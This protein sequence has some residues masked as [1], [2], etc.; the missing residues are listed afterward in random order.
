MTESEDPQSAPAFLE[1]ADIETASDDYASRFAGPTGEWM[2]GLQARI[3]MELLGAT[4]AQ[5]VL[6]VGGGHAQLALP[7]SSAGFDVTVTGSDGSCRQRIEQEV[8]AGTI[9][10]DIADVLKL[11]YPDHSFDAVICFRLITHC[12][13]WEQVVSE[14]CR[15][16]RK[17]VVVDY[18][19]SQSL[20]A[21]A[22]GLFGA[23]KKIERNTRAWRLFRH[24]QVNGAFAARDFKLDRRVGQFFF[25]MVL[26]RALKC[27]CISA[28]LEAIAGAVGLKR[29]WGSPVIARYIPA[30]AGALSVQTK[31]RLDET[32]ILPFFQPSS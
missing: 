26:H 28:T 14:L 9:Q 20:N 5:T 19:T 27:R 10:F 2:L 23:K 1:T 18:P 30:D 31:V 7:L 3:T 21:V 12:E 17:A 22:P 16:A 4:G 13:R 6:D 25:P 15:V 8:E 29:L 32:S 24:D 11:P